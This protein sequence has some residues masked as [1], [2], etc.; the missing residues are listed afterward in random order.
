MMVIILVKK[1]YGFYKS[2]NISRTKKIILKK[3]KGEYTKINCM[4]VYILATKTRKWILK[5]S[6][7]T[8]KTSDYKAKCSHK[9]YN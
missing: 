9:L 6:T 7:N 4:F 3:S 2:R 5:K 8:W 1:S